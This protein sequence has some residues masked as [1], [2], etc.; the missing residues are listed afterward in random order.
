MRK[1]EL[2]EKKRLQGEEVFEALSLKCCGYDVAGIDGR[3]WEPQEASWGHW[4]PRDSKLGSGST[5]PSGSS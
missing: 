5:T 2:V 1:A 4:A 3:I